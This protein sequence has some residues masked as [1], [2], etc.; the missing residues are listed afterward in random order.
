M[1]LTRFAT[2]LLAGLLCG[3]AKD[4]LDLEDIPKESLVEIDS[5]AIDWQKLQDG[6][7]HLPDDATSKLDE[8]FGQSSETELKDNSGAKYGFSRNWKRGGL[9]VTWN[10]N[11]C[12]YEVIIRR[13]WSSSEFGAKIGDRLSA[14]TSKIRPS[15]PPPHASGCEYAVDGSPNWL[16]STHF[17]SVLGWDR[18]GLAKLNSRGGKVH[19]TDPVVTEIVFR[20]ARQTPTLLPR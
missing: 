17:T 11:G 10:N 1:R 12:I 9:T 2:V 7:P 6:C 15:I 19:P 14:V 13:R 18:E 16:L 3:C 20:N 4:Y 5:P 8:A